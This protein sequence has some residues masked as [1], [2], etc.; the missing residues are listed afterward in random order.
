[1][2]RPVKADDD[3]TTSALIRARRRLWLDQKAS[4][5][6]RKR[7]HVAGG[8]TAIVEYERTKV[9][10]KVLRTARRAVLIE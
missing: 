1:M 10:G 3:R 7:P 2:E 9:S 8:V 4:V 5:P 6:C